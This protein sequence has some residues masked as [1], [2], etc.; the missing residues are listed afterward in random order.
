MAESGP[1]LDEALIG[2]WACTDEERGSIVLDL[3]R[4]GD[5]GHVT[6]TSTEKDRE[7]EIE[8]GRLITARLERLTYAS[9]GKEEDGKSNWTLV[10]YELRGRN[11]MTIYMDNSRFWTDAVRNKIVSGRIEE[12]K[13]IVLTSKTVVTASSDELRKVVLGSGSVIFD[14]TPVCEFTRSA[15]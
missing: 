3:V 4:D 7:P 6:V 11:R 13:G 15:P 10:R 1:A 14:D 12:S 9:V 5:T 8:Q 2:R